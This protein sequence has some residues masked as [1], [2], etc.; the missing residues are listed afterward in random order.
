MKYRQE[1]VRESVLLASVPVSDFNHTL[2]D[3]IGFKMLAILRPT[4]VR[5]FRLNPAW[6]APQI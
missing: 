4:F 5:S 3:C 1:L 6:G 2:S